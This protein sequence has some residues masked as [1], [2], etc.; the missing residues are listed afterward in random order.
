VN[1]YPIV[2]LKDS[3]S[4]DLAQA[5]VDLVLSDAGQSILKDAGF[6]PAG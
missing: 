6:A 2:A 1:T 4:G 3:E 5:F